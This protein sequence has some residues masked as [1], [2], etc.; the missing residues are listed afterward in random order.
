MG[1][2]KEPREVVKAALLSD[3]GLG[4]VAL[5]P[6]ASSVSAKPQSIDQTIAPSV[7]VQLH[8]TPPVSA[9]TR[10]YVPK[11]VPGTSAPKSPNAAAIMP[12]PST[13]R[14]VNAPGRSAKRAT[15]HTH[16]P[17]R[18]S[19]CRITITMPEP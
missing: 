13:K 10:K 17:I 1:A 9:V 6:P 15:V 8:Q 14:I 7:R 19:A 3:D 4:K 2:Y 18:I 11:Y 5:R 12:F 16:M